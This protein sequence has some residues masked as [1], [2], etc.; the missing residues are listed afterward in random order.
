MI[1]DDHDKI[2]S[3]F[4]QFESAAESERG[5]LYRNLKRELIP[6]MR[7]EETV[8]YPVLKNNLRT[9]DASLLSLEQHR[10]ADVILSQLDAIPNQDE[11][12]KPKL[13]VLKDVVNTH[14]KEEESN[15]FSETSKAIPEEELNNM[16]APF[17]REKESV[18]S[19]TLAGEPTK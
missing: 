1:K 8:V 9:H 10:L 18:V 2:S 4:Q 14:I 12:W 15:V 6:H 17:Q 16:A 3:I 13:L 11:T 7:A 19:T 5:Y